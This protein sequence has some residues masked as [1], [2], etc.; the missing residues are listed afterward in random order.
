MIPKIIHY[1]WFGGKDKPESFYRYMATWKRL[2]PDY[3]FKEWN[4]EN[5]DVNFWIYS[6]EAYA[7]GSFAHV[8][9]VCRIYAL[10]VYGGVYLDTDVELCES[11]DPY[12]SDNSF[13]G[14]EDEYNVGTCVIGA[15]SN[16]EWLKSVLDYYAGTHFINILGHPIKTPNTILLTQKIFPHLAE[17]DMPKIYPVG[18][19][20]DYNHGRELSKI[21]AKVVAIHHYNASWRKKKTLMTRLRTICLGL[22]VRY[23]WNQWTK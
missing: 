1:C 13:I 23:F 22:K 6:R 15:E 4:E 8:S 11:L 17:S 16:R 7:M 12:L 2:L 5:F 21:H 14:M 20:C 19:F 3:E 9:D 10:N 18:Y